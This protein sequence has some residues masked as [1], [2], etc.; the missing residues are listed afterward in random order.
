MMQERHTQRTTYD[1]AIT[2]YSKAASPKACLPAAG[3]C[4]ESSNA[5]LHPHQ[6]SECDS[7]PEWAVLLLMCCSPAIVWGG[8]T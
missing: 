4:S 5:A 1:R 7:T 8:Y 3:C 6:W 2:T